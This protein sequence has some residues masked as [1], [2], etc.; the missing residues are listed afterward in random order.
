MFHPLLHVSRSVEEFQGSERR[1]II[2][3][4]VRSQQEFIQFDRRHKLGFV[5][6]AKRFNVAI[7]RSQ[8]LLI[9]VGNP[10]LLEK[11]EHWKALLHYCVDNGGYV[12]CEYQKNS[13]GTVDEPLGSA[14]QG[15]ANM[16]LLNDDDSETD[17][18][19][20]VKISSTTAQEGPEWRVEE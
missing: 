9:V 19:D 13:D 2:I 10:F 16:S 7:T 4:T 15:I 20:Y 3:S 11:D 17:A 6:N 14:L 12:G 1:V 8:A 18:E 5:S